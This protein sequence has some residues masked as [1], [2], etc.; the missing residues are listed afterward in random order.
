ML[1]NPG[2][3]RRRTWHRIL[4]LQWHPSLYNALPIATGSK[5]LSERAF[6]S[7]SLF[8]SIA[9]LAT[10]RCNGEGTE[11]SLRSQRNWEKLG[12][13]GSPERHCAICKRK[14]SKRESERESN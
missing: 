2:P 7:L 4:L 10:Q 6:L 14:V 5:R 9:S 8:L 3:H 12:V 1:W 13:S 11:R